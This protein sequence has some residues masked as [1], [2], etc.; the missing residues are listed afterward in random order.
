MFC[1]QKEEIAVSFSVLFVSLSTCLILYLFRSTPI[2]T[3]VSSIFLE[4]IFGFSFCCKCFYEFLL[5]T[6]IYLI[7]FLY[8]IIVL[9]SPWKKLKL[10]PTKTSPTSG[11]HVIIGLNNGSVEIF[12]VETLQKVAAQE[13]H[14]KGVKSMT[15]WDDEKL[16]VIL[17]E[18]EKEICSKIVLK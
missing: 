16:L 4:I 8:V 12:D 7:S 18:K 9:S 13:C 5:L 6:L 1:W 2:A 3:I 17:I 15:L 10:K 14:S 11:G